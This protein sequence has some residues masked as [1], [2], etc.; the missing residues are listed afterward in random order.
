MPSFAYHA[1][2]LGFGARI[3]KPVCDIIPSQASVA[4]ASSGGEGY[5]EVKN[6]NYKNIITFD[7]ARSYVAGSFEEENGKRTYN[8]LAT[9]TIRNLDVAGMVQVEHLVARISS[10]HDGLDDVEGKI[11]FDGSMMRGVTIAGMP[12]DVRLDTGLFSR[13][14]TYESF[15]QR[16]LRDREVVDKA[17]MFAWDA[18]LPG[19]KEPCDPDELANPDSPFMKRRTEWLTSR[20]VIPCSLLNDDVSNDIPQYAAG[21]PTPLADLPYVHRRG[22]VIHVREFGKVFLGEVHIKRGQRR[23]NMLRFELGCPVCGD[24]AGGSVEGNGMPTVPP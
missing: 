24:A 9:V 12:L 19:E 2:A 6:F 3:D 10:R 5:A 13:Y 8:T 16:F 20:G 21:D 4:L 11:T 23:L 22:Y 1:N 15:T 18:Q 7:E 17:R 14:P